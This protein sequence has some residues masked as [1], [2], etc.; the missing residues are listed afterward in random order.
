M[1]ALQSSVSLF[2]NDL[3]FNLLKLS[4]RFIRFDSNSFFLFH[5]M[6][7]RSQE[8]PLTLNIDRLIDHTH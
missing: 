5:L 2:S 1:K 8:S 6:N 3:I 7:H 4:F